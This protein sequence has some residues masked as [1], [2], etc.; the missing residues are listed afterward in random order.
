MTE[1]EHRRLLDELLS[2]GRENECVEFKQNKVDAEEIGE[3]ISA[4]SNSAALHGKRAGYLVWGIEDGTSRIVGTGFRPSKTKVG[5]EEL[6]NWLCTH[7]FPRIHFEFAELRLDGLQLVFLKVRPAAHTPV[8]FRD[9]EF[10]RVGSYKKLLRDYPEKA[11]VLWSTLS[12]TP[13]EAE[14]ARDGCS[15]DDVLGLIDY[16]S[17]FELMGMPLPDN[18]AGILERLAAESVIARRGD[19]YDVS[20]LGAILFARD[21]EQFRSLARKAVRVVSYRGK[22]RLE[23]IREQVGRRGYAVGFSGLVSYVNTMLPRNEVI[24]QALRREVPMFPEL[25]IRELLANALIHQDFR[26]TG[27]GPMVELF[28]DRIEITNPGVPLIDV[29]RFLDHPPQSRNELL[30]RFMR[31]LNICEERGSGIDRVV[32]QMELYQLPAPE[33]VVMG[34]HT[35]GVLYALMKL[36]EMQASDRI[37]ACYLH[38][39]LRHVEG[40]PMTNATLRHRL[41]I[42]DQNYSIA[43]RII[44]ETI[45]AGQLK[46][47]DPTSSSKRHARYLPFWA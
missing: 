27:T 42:A 7:L 32:F 44:R 40:E 18:R 36:S 4:L 23:A 24:G 28:A 47:H 20:N 5:N 39:C 35:R 12:T 6:E 33:F 25:A 10:V 22:G 31:R 9:R 38:A 46:A 2:S 15:E 29:L 37:R 19:R 13:F 3:Y 30:A 11:R 17:Y 41:G 8:R 14:I 45:E 26:V 1:A 43:S 34:S 16:V 21:L